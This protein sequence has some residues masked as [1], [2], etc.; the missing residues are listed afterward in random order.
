[1]IVQGGERQV[2][3]KSLKPDTHYSILVTA[4][5]RNTEGGSA[6]A[7]GKTSESITLKIYTFFKT[8]V[9]WKRL[10]EYYY[11]LVENI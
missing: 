6:S 5:Y 2:V 1:M 7:Q 3:L 10:G 4:E 9:A 8:T 11:Y